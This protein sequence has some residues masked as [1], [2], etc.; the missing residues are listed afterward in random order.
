M[1]IQFMEFFILKSNWMKFFFLF[2]IYE[3]EVIENEKPIGRLL[4]T[5]L[6]TFKWKNTWY[7]GLKLTLLTQ[8]APT[9]H[10]ARN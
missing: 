5:G 8:L 2:R 3:D 9:N 10:I 7:T 1:M 6:I 4:S